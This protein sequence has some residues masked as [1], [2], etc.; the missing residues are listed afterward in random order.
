MYPPCFRPDT[1]DG[2]AAEGFGSGR[3]DKSAVVGIWLACGIRFLF[4]ALQILLNVQLN[5]YD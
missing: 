1:L 3:K 2:R 5:F 4:T